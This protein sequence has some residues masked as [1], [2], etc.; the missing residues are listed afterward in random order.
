MKLGIF[1]LLLIQIVLGLSGV[2]YALL[3]RNVINSAV[4]GQQKHFFYSVGQ[5]AFLAIFQLILRAVQRFLEECC[6]SGLEND[7]KCR[8]FSQLLRIDYGPMS[9]VHSAEWMNRLTEDTTVVA[10][11]MTEIFPGLA[12]MAIRLVSAVVALLA[13]EPRFLYLIFPAGV[14]LLV[15]STAFRRKMKQLQRSIRECDGSLRS[16]LQECL[17][18]MVV[19]RSYA[20]ED[21]MESGGETRMKDH[22]K[23]RMK[24]NHFS[25]LCNLGFGGLMNGAYVVGACFCGWRILAGQ[26]SYGTLSAVLQLIGQVQSPFAH[27]SGYF[28]RYYAMLVSAE[29]LMEAQALPTHNAAGTRTLSEIQARYQTEFQGFGLKDASFTY[30]PP[31]V[32]QKKASAQ[33]QPLILSGFNLEIRK[34][35]YV[36]FTGASGCGKSTVLKLLMNLY[37][38]DRGECYLDFKGERVTLDGSWQKLFAYVPQG[39][40]LMSG[41]IGDIVSFAGQEG[42]PEESRIW[43]A[44]SIACAD[45]FVK[46]LE[47][48]IDTQLGERGHGLSEGQLQRLSIARAIYSGRPILMLDECTSALDEDT[49]QQLLSNLRAMSDQTVLIVTH[50]PAALAIC[51]RVVCF[52]QEDSGSGVSIPGN[53]TL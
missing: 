36:A 2:L 28:P 13:L 15:F 21:A 16:F 49:E 32:E 25:N 47:K 43:K 4:D 1:L 33:V 31:V 10:N 42:E 24:R 39:N 6:R 37:Q 41:T 52:Q 9:A 7:F 3:L 40:H 44:L 8:L 18:S 30:L 46:A 22:R 14:L 20:M 17:S 38:L 51:D 23:A 50:R 11:G 53:P 27:L 26:M 45:G 29:R 48:G 35:E 5:F 34:G 19:V 12:G